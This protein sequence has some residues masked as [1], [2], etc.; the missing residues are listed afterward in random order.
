MEMLSS[1]VVGELVSRSISF[2]FSKLEKDTAATAQED[3]QQ[4]RLL[5]LRSG[6]IVQDAEQRYVPSKAM[7]QQLKA[8]RDE[9]FRGHYVLDVVS[10]RAAL[11]GGGGEDVGGGEEAG[12]RACFS[13]SRFNPAKR[14]RF[15]S[16]DASENS[17]VLGGASPGE[18]QQ[19]VRSLGIMIGDM[20][21]FVMFLGS[22]PPL[23]R[24]PYSAHMFVEKCMFGR[25]M[26]KETVMEFLLKNEPPPPGAEHLGVLPIVG[27]AHIGKST[28]VEHVCDDEKV[29]DHFSL[30]LFYTGNDLKDVTVSSFKDKCLI[31]HH[32]D[33]ASSDERVLVVIELLDDVDDETWSNLYSSQRS[34]AQG[35]KMIIT[36]RSERI[37]RFGTAQALRLKCLSVE[38]YWYLFKTAAFGGDDP[39]QHPKMASIA[40]EMANLMQ[41]SFIFA[42]TGA[43][44]LNANFST[45]SWSRILTGLKGYM[46]K[47]ASLIGEYPDD[48]NGKDYPR[49][50]WNVM[51]K[52]PDKY[53]MLHDIYQR[54]SGQ[55]V[56]DI[57]Y[58]DL[59]SGRANPPAGKY[60]ILLTKSRI[61]PY[62]NYMCACE[63]RDM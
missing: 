50:T 48:I 29:R 14:V 52:K 47:N 30:I 46:Q 37:E 7:L 33:N 19:V 1:A 31:K 62:F 16:N 28:L 49:Y 38:A 51:K 53:F 24:Q 39:G 34:I 40:L 26:E 44:L 23:Y 45:K 4:L 27:P 54:G 12:R 9:T 10:C 41:G 8:L 22:Y 63:I 11:G 32:A 3:L 18:L 43:A 56:P 21:E 35:S 17:S 5:L 25:H 58:L 59:Q 13:L 15:P 6:A 60:D 61:P 36:S 2:L 55:E 42:S 20:K 57:S